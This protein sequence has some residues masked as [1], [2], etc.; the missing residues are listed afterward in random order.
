MA[1]AAPFLR[2]LFQQPPALE[3]LRCAL[4]VPGDEGE[5]GTGI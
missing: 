1:F 5:K 2:A 4:Q 3:Q